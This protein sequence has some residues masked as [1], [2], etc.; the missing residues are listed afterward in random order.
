MLLKISN[1][2]ASESYHKQEIQDTMAKKFEETSATTG[3]FTFELLE[4]ITDDF[5][6]ENIIGR[7]AYGVVYMVIYSDF[8]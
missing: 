3:E 4:E 6:D 7:G 2:Q 5:S 8:N 1:I